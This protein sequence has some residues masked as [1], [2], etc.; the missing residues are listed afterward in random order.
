M[1]QVTQPIA[2]AYQWQRCDQAGNACANVA[3]ASSTSYAPSMADLGLTLRFSV[4]AANGTGSSSATSAATAPVGV[5]PT[6][7]APPQISGT[8]QVGATALTA[9]PGTWAGS[10]PIALAYQW[11]RCDAE[12]ECNDVAGATGPTLDLTGDMAGA[13]IVVEVTATNAVGSATAYSAATA[14]VE[15]A[16]P[17]AP[18]SV[19]IP[20]VSGNALENGVVSVD[21]GTWSGTTPLSF[22]YQWNRCNPQGGSCTPIQSATAPAY[23]VT[24]ED[25]A[26][27][28]AVAVTA[29]N[30]AG[31]ATAQS[32]ATSL[33]AQAAYPQVIAKD[34]PRGFWRLDERTGR[35][36]PTGPL[37]GTLGSYSMNPTLGVPGALLDPA[38]KAVRLNGVDQRVIVNSP[39]N[40]SLDF[41]TSNFSVETWFRTAANGEESP[42]SKQTLTGSFW[43]VTV[44]DDP[45]HVGQVR[46][47]IFDGTVTRTVYGPSIRVKTTTTG[48][49]WRCSTIEPTESRCTS[50]A[51][52]KF[53]AG[54]SPGS[55]TNT[56]PLRI[57]FAANF[58][59]F[60]GDIDEAAVY[61]GLLS[62]ARLEAHYRGGVDTSAP[63]P[64][65]NGP[66]NGTTIG[67]RLPMF[68]GT[69][70]ALVGDSNVLTINLYAGASAT[71]TPIPVFHHVARSVRRLVSHRHHPAGIRHIHSAGHS[72]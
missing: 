2:Y 25:V 28:L 39:A 40:G 59:Y 35:S 12:H 50:T 21:P 54:A 33:I 8:A 18:V 16:T 49:T 6:N 27:T 72:S 14:P 62:P 48:T 15:P 43:D 32:A 11:Q 66:P 23:T 31:S 68:T 1:D 61:S 46:A 64:V 30:V 26:F 36:P 51:F 7:T 20:T 5:P 19:A 34:G 65:L 24:A 57:G 37:T 52:A 45:G 47:K 4:T 42:I 69:A 17:V 13:T 53:T 67:T 29:S 55:V 70:G 22:A 38:D 60:N 71:G 58:P 44:T 63:V 41:G 10:Q 3:G 56:S 9:D